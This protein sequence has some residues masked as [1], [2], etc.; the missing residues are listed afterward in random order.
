MLAENGIIGLLGYL[1]TFGAIIWTNIKN[2]FINK[3]PHNLM[4][5]GSTIALFLQ[6]LTEYNF[7]NSS[8]MKIYWLVLACLVVLVKEYNETFSKQELLGYT[9]DENIMI[10]DILKKLNVSNLG[11]VDVNNPV[12]LNVI[13][14]DEYMFLKE[15]FTRLIHI[16]KLLELSDNEERKSQIN[17]YKQGNLSQNSHHCSKRVKAIFPSSTRSCHRKVATNGS[18]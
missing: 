2:C 1:L 10:R 7:G 18:E 12:I 4:I 8:V 3:N 16:G 15:I 6:G 9:L 13:D 14:A 11:S 17:Q 5:I